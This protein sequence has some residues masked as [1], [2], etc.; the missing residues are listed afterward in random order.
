M[1]GSL[2]SPGRV[3]TR[4][5]APSHVAFRVCEHVG[6]RIKNISRLNGWPVHTPVNASPH[7]SRRI[8]HD[9]G[10]I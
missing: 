10:T 8:A 1:P 6:T 3:G 9:S 7:A 5:F 2:T 4:G